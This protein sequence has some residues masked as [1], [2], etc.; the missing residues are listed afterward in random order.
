MRWNLMASLIGTAA[1]L[2]WAPPASAIG[3]LGGA[4]LA[5]TDQPNRIGGEYCDRGEENCIRGQSNVAVFR[6]ARFDC[7]QFRPANG[8]QYAY[9]EALNR[10][11]ARPS[12]EPNPQVGLWR[13]RR[14]GS[15][16]TDGGAAMDL[17]EGIQ[18]PGLRQAL[19]FEVSGDCAEFRFGRSST[20][21]IRRDG[22]RRW[23]LYPGRSQRINFRIWIPVPR[24]DRVW[25][26]FFDVRME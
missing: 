21:E 11:F 8:S 1:A 22:P 6:V 4:E 5:A 15:C 9:A 7:R 2:S 19:L 10:A 12:G 20:L 16:Y 25:A 18:L 26:S 3:R 13:C 14:D 17:T 23:F 24:P